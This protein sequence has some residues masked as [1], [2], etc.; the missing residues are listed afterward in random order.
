MSAIA[1]TSRPSMS[2]G[3]ARS[4]SRQTL[5]TSWKCRPS[6]SSLARATKSASLLTFSILL[7]S[8]LGAL[9]LPPQQGERLTPL[10]DA[11]DEQP[12]LAEPLPGLVH[13]RLAE[14]SR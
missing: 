9:Q 7:L 13:L 14:K 4:P 10:G 1:S 8:R 6:S 5:T 11:L 3:V 2:V 12:L